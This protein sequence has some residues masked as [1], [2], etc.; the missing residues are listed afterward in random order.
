[1]PSSSSRCTIIVL[2]KTVA[3]ILLKDNA[4]YVNTF[5]QIWILSGKQCYKNT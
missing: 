1:M 2:T 4:V 5:G 3:K